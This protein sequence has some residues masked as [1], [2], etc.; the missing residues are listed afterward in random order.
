MNFEHELGV[1]GVRLLAYEEYGYLM[2]FEEALKRLEADF[3][4][5]SSFIS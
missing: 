2:P 1:K 3:M 5:D 4:K